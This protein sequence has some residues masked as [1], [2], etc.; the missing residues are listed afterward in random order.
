MPHYEYVCETCGWNFTLLQS[1]HA[2][3]GET[4]CPQCGDRKTRKLV[5]SF[6]TSC[7]DNTVCGLGSS[8]WGGG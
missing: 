6:S 1:L 2:K 8:N 4:A 5:S 3:E 7:G